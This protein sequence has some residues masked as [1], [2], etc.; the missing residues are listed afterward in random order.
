MDFAPAF[1]KKLQSVI[2]LIHKAQKKFLRCLHLI[3]V[4]K[5]PTTRTKSV[6]VWLRGQ[7]SAHV[8]LPVGQKLDL[9]H[10]LT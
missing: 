3:C 9:L 6:E 1:F 7:Y 2:A 10:F 4:I 5:T 8:T